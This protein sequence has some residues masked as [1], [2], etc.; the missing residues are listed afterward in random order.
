MI[1]AVYGVV[2][3]LVML[4]PALRIRGPLKAGAQPQAPW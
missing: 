1:L 4:L 2:F 3:L